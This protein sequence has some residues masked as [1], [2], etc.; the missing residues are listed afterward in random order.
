MAA[1]TP[2]RQLILVKTFRIPLQSWV[3]EL[4][5]GLMD[6]PGITEEELAAKELREETGFQAEKIVPL[7]A[8]PFN[9]GLV[10]DYLAVYLGLNAVKVSEP[11]LETGEDIEVIS[12]PLAEA[13]NFLTNPPVG[14][15]VDIKLF[16]V[17]F[18][19]KLFED[20]A[21]NP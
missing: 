12:L 8:G 20:L 9:A 5:A 17:I 14:V 3:I 21:E 10:E 11:E 15:L 6:R 1:V 18:H 7:M 19:P 4:C 13:Y 16:G 2:D